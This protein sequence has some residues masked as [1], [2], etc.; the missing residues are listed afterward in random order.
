M[1]EPSLTAVV[2]RRC[3]GDV[4][5]NVGGAM[6]PNPSTPI[7]R[8]ATASPPETPCCAPVRA[9]LADGE[10]ESGGAASSE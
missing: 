8:A 10:T 5:D 7:L 6:C 3:E 4:D 2:D 9:M 1:R